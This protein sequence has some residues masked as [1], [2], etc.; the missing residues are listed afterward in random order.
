MY[1]RVQI[2]L[3]EPPTSSKLNAVSEL[4]LS[5]LIAKPLNSLIQQH[6]LKTINHFTFLSTTTI[7]RNQSGC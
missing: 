4:S 2:A 5:P 3:R 7:A 6:I 1:A